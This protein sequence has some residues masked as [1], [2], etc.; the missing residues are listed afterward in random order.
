[1]SDSDLR[2]KIASDLGLSVDALANRTTP[3]LLVQH[4]RHI[5]HKTGLGLGGLNRGVE[6]QIADL[7]INVKDY[8]A[9]GDG[10]TDDTAAVQALID[11]VSLAGGGIVYFPKGTYL[12][13]TLVLKTNVTLQGNSKKSVTLKATTDSVNPAMFTIDS[14]PVQDSWVKN[15]TIYGAMTSG[16]KAF[17]IQAVGSGGVPDHGGWWESGLSNIDISNFDGHCIHL[18]GGSGGSYAYN[19]PIQFLLFDRVYAYNNVNGCSIYAE[20]QVAQIECLACEFDG[21]QE[22][23]IATGGLQTASVYLNTTGSVNFSRCVF[24]NREYGATLVNTKAI[25]F[26]S[27]WFENLY[28]GIW[29]HTSAKATVVS[30]HFA[31]VGSDGAGTGVILKTT[32]AGSIVSIHNNM[33]GTIDKHY[34]SENEHSKITP[35][36]DKSSVAFVTSG[37]TKQIS[38]AADGSITPYKASTMLVNTSATSLKTIIANNFAVGDE[39]SIIPWGGT[40]TLASGGNISSGGFTLPLVLPQSSLVTFVRGDLAFTWILKS[41]SKLPTQTG[42]PA[43]ATDLAT[44]ITLAN[45]L[46]SKLIALGLIS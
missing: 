14:G 8:G 10:I 30:S 21:T 38:I 12:I 44:V 29:A 36:Y 4:Q 23:P 6:D 27:C 13:N 42:T 26:N 40:I 15:L 35:I 25:T 37:Q 16:Q 20:G 39:V 24:Q 5:L 31:N 11:S 33:I 41:I 2:S 22:P 43:D 1:M 45:D 28:N 7:A 17:Y 32:T 19:L 34:S 18:V 9:I 3:E 46:K